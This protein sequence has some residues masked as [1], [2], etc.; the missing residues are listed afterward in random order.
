M[1]L[2]EAKL[3]I[4]PGA[5]G[6]QRLTRLVGMAKAK[7]LIYTGKR[8]N[9]EEAERIGAFLFSFQTLILVKRADDRAGEYIGKST[10]NSLGDGFNSLK[11][12][13][14]FRSVPFQPRSRSRF[15][16]LTRQPRWH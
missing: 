5:G 13:P 16:I 3:G 4:I 2:P 8:L 9:G 6:T 1:S 7:E 12:D 14:Y 11:A 10:G 15:Q